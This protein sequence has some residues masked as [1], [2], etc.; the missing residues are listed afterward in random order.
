MQARYTQIRE[1][2]RERI[3]R[4]D[5]RVG[6]QLPTEVELMAE[7]DVS[8]GTVS[9]AIRDLE[10][11]GLIVRRRGAGT[12]VRADLPEAA[13]GPAGP[14]GAAPPRL[15]LIDR[16]PP[17]ED[18]TGY[19][20]GMV[21]EALA[22]L[23]SRRDV[24]LALQRVTADDAEARES[25]L[26]VARAVIARGP[27][28]VLYSALELPADLMPLN[29]EVVDLLRENGMRVLLTGRDVVVPPDRS[30][31]PRVSYDNRRAG[32]LLARHLAGAGYRR[33]AFVGTP[34][35][36]SSVADRLAGF[37][38]GVRLY[39]LAEDERL[40]VACDPP[41][42]AA[43]ARLL[44]EARADAIVCKCTHSAAR[45]AGILA[46]R[47]VRVGPDVGL[48]GFDSSPVA[49]L[50]PVPLT[51]AA[52]PVRPFAA[53]VLKQA[54]ALHADPSVADLGEHTTLDCEL[55]ARASTRRDVSHP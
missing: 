29:R 53:A 16:C 6:D 7:Y 19:P 42:E 25:M 48:A 9:R 11:G 51:T 22:E 43:V 15:T 35:A 21:Y 13:A 54:L 31:L 40:V 32:T 27:Q 34:A 23:C 2:V 28:V 36:S 26:A 45:V 37:R 10:V 39:G 5:Y 20:T 14:A 1:G 17:S 38:D 44:T 52:L 55:I 4:R 41:T 30:R 47:G 49:A 33:A 3:L 46:R 8:R 50:L 24:G 12:F 18:W